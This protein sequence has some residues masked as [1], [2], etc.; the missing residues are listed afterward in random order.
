MVILL[1]CFLLI[2]IL[3]SCMAAMLTIGNSLGGTVGGT[4]YLAEDGDINRAG[5]RYSEW[6]VDLL[7]QALDAEILF[8][9]YDEYRHNLGDAGHDPLALIACLTAKHDDFTLAAVEGELQ[10]ISSRL[11]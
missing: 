5:L 4:T 8:P 3:Q 1:L 11:N 6:E 7:L 10:D 2:M 9:G